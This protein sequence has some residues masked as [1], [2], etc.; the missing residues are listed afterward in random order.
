M[1]D[2]KEIREP[3][4]VTQAHIEEAADMRQGA[5]GGVR[6]SWNDV[7]DKLEASDEDWGSDM[8]SPAI[9]HL[10]RETNKLVR[11]RA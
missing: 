1:G 11:E 3:S 9:T 10:K 7:I 5:Y 2:W 8:T 4:D 6:L